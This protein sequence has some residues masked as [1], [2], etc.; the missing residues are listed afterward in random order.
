M[1]TITSRIWIFSIFYILYF[2]SLCTVLINQ[3]H[4]GL[5]VG[6]YRVLEGGRVTLDCDIGGSTSTSTESAVTT[7]ATVT[8]ESE[9][10]KPVRDEETAAFV[11]DIAWYR[12]G[13]KKFCVEF[14]YFNM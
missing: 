7:A 10:V 9:T 14:K 1:L 3:S 11:P 6:S 4:G 5:P 13:K 12:N 2:P 8:A